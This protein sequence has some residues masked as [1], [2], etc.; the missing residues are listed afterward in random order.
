VFSDLYGST[1]VLRQ[2]TSSQAKRR[3]RRALEVIN[4]LLNWCCLMRW[5]GMRV[6]L[7]ELK[8]VVL[9]TGAEEAGPSPDDV[10]LLRDAGPWL[11]RPEQRHGGG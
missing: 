8:W 3:G 9:I 1:V 2:L 11:R 4:C 7:S 5:V 10:R 6:E